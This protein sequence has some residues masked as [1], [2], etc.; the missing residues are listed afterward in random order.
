[1][2]TTGVSAPKSWIAYATDLVAWRRF[3]HQRY[4]D[5]LADVATLRDAI[6]DYHT[7]RRM[8]DPARRL[9]ASSWN[10]A[11]AAI[12]PFYEWAQEEGLV[13]GVPFRYRLHVARIEGQGPMVVRRN[14]AKESEGRPHGTMRW[15]EADHLELFLAAGLARRSVR[16]VI[17]PL[18]C[19]G[20]F[21]ELG[22]CGLEV[23][24]DLGGDDYGSDS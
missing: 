3:L 10:R 2:P 5:L 1:L 9:A 19:L 17:H 13:E 8:G 22:E 14:L 24:D 18:Q 16:M 11:I 21:A 4:L 20:E 23:F 7:D 6:A 15:L 12:A